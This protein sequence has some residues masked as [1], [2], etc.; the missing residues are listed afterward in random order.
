MS[1][2]KEKENN[3]LTSFEEDLVWMSY[4]YCIG[5]HTIA[6]YMHANNIAKYCYNRLQ[7]HRMEFISSDIN[8]EICNVLQFSGFIHFN[9]IYSIPEDQ[10]T[11]LDTVYSIL[12]KENI[13][14]YDK[15]KS[16]K[17]ITISWNHDRKDYDYDIYYFDDTCKDK[18]YGRSIDDL[19]DLEPW[20]SL[21]N[22][23]NKKNHK[24][25]KLTDGTTVEYFESWGT[26]NR[27]GNLTFEKFKHPID[28]NNINFSRIIPEENI[29][30]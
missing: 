29:V 5:R 30:D 8:R 12:S 11:P 9:S 21:A 25:C 26:I 28:N 27:G 18:G 22:L 10:F 1:K 15:I 4:R 13:N 17:N 23:F 3:L 6:A 7:E 16:I 24:S 2:K 20:Q 19:T 14:T